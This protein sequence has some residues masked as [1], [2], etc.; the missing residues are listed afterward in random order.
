[1]TP[2]P[3]WTKLGLPNPPEDCNGATPLDLFM[4]EILYVVA[5]D[6]KQMKKSWSRIGGA[7]E[8]LLVGLGAA[9][10]ALVV[11]NQGVKLLGS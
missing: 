7:W 8:T 4:L 9:A 3:D 11:V 2:D 1:M 10:L 5:G 6:V